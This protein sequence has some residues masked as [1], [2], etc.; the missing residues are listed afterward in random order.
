MNLIEDIKRKK[1][2]QQI[3]DE[4]VKEQLNIYLKKNPKA[5]RFLESEH[6]K[7]SAKY[8]KIIKEVR[9]SL[10]RSYGL[11]R[12]KTN[13]AE[14]KSAL[15]KLKKSMNKKAIR[16]EAVREILW[17]HSSTRER[18]PFYDKL[19]KK[20]FSLTGKPKTILDLGCG[21]NYFSLLNHNLV[22]YGYDI[23]K[24]EIKVV[25]DY[26]KSSGKAAGAK[27]LN[28]LKITGLKKLPKGDVA[29]LLK[30]TDIIDKADKAKSHKN[31]ENVIKA[32]PAKY[33]IISFPTITMSGRKM[34]FPRRKWI[35]LM[36]KRQGY[37]FKS[38][39]L[40]NELFYV[41]KK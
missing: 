21:L 8:K 6:S 13:F 1:E 4:F 39:E 37:G 22:Y 23:A 30:M 32:I 11:F 7:R 20:I 24:N 36:C 31:T 26:I 38:F 29:L 9:T 40:G 18:L 25:N 19:Y 5:K 33:I 34:N 12:E 16:E 35:E 41:I 2:L 3:S 17:S 28:I 10:R 14:I 27:I 15:E